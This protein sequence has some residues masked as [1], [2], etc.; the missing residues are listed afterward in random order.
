M[1]SRRIIDAVIEAFRFAPAPAPGHDWSPEERA[2]LAHAREAFFVAGATRLEALL[3]PQKWLQA[4]VMPATGISG[5]RILA[6]VVLPAV[7]R[8][9]RERTLRRF[10][11]MRKPPGLR[12]RFQAGGS[13][14]SVAALERRIAAMLARAERARLIRHHDRDVYEAETY[15]F[16]GEVGLDLCHEQ[17]D[18]DS[19]AAIELLRLGARD[20]LTAEPAALSILLLVDLIRKV[21]PDEWEHWDVWCNMRL[22]R[23]LPAA[24]REERRAQARLLEANR[25]VL[26]RFVFRS[27]AAIRDLGAAERRIVERYFVRSSRFAKRLNDAARRA[28]LLYG[29]RKILPFV[30]IFHWNRFGLDQRLQS[31]LSFAMTRLLDPKRT[32][33]VI[34]PV[35]N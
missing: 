22:T 29:V 3:D 8:W 10:F 30:I 9:K 11:F 33:S 34:A 18:Y 16:G 13:K 26:E 25:E 27:H 15:Q 23:R 7:K 4:S 20:R 24:S 35:R 5:D 31:L 17:F 12:L 2:M 14:S 19:I 32:G 1:R 21:V 28:Q 6:E